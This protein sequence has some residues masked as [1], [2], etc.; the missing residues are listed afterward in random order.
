MPRGYRADAWDASLIT[1]PEYQCRVHPS[2]YVPSFAGMRIWEEFD[3]DSQS[4]GRHSHASLRVGDRAHHLDGWPPASARVCAAY[5]AG[6][7]HRQMGRR[8]S[9]RHHHA[10]ERRLDPPQRV[11]A[12]RSRRG[13]RALHPARG[14]SD[15]HDGDLAT[16]P[17]SP[18]PSSA[19]ATTS[20]KSAARSRLIHAKAWKRSSGPRA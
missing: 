1:L 10:F 12:Q 7:L 19:R 4:P 11:A 18:S 3:K 6:F 9:G 17:I 2:D 20:M 5:L 8:R 15:H 14:Q 13:H 16:L